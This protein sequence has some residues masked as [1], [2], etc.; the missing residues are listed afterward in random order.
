MPVTPPR[1]Q[2]QIDKLIIPPGEQAEPVTPPGEQAEPVTPRGK[3]AKP[4]TPPGEQDEP[5]TPP[6][7]QAEP[8]TPPRKKGQIDGWHKERH[9]LASS[10]KELKPG[11]SKDPNLQTLQPIPLLDKG[12]IKS[13]AHLI[14]A[15]NHEDLA[16]KRLIVESMKG[17][18]FDV[19]FME[20]IDFKKRQYFERPETIKYL[21]DWLGKD[22]ILLDAELKRLI[23]KELSDPD[24]PR[25]IRSDEREDMLRMIKHLKNLDTHYIDGVGRGRRAEKNPESTFSSIIKTALD[26]DIKII[27]VDKNEIYYKF[28]GEDR[29]EKF[30]AHASDIVLKYL[31]N[32][33]SCKS[34]F[35]TGAAHAA[36]TYGEIDQGNPYPNIVSLGERLKMPTLMV[37]DKETR[38]MPKGFQ[39]LA[40]IAID[41]SAI[42]D[43]NGVFHSRA[44][45]KQIKQD[46]DEKTSV[47][48]KKVD[49]NKVLRVLTK[50]IN[51]K[52]NDDRSQ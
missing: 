29:V 17:K 15:E 8:V 48:A 49:A 32:N 40:G 22:E 13:A 14:I 5:V 16:P 38:N 3:Q 6:G 31:E 25:L 35:L 28:T 2:D 52:S 1:Q 24:T 33:A 30:N 10:S 46:D 34:R 7:E 36:R 41:C 44:N 11:T 37:A 45:N 50:A 4:V 43:V 51:K 12:S 39:T 27:P 26:N 47:P 18:E 9:L 21:K 19:L 42:I 23:N 20:H